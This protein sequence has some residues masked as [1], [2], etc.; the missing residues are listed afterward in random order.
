MDKYNVKRTQSTVLPSQIVDARRT[1]TFTF[2]FAPSHKRCTQN[3]STAMERRKQNKTKEQQP[4]WVYSNAQRSQRTM[5][6]MCGWMHINGL[7][8]RFVYVCVC[9]GAAARTIRRANACWCGRSRSNAAS[10]SMALCRVTIWIFLN[11]SRR[12]NSIVGHSIGSS[13]FSLIRIW[14]IL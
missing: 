2:T 4:N 3:L 13:G 9:P 10:R 14:W 1:L 5:Q 12:C 6:T 8:N 7:S 11:S